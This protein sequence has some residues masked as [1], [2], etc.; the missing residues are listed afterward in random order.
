M[1]A[2]LFILLGT[3]FFLFF[4]TPSDIYAQLMINE[5][6]PN[7]SGSPSEP[8][9][10]IELYNSGNETVDIS[11][12]TISDTSGSTKSYT[13]PGMTLAEGEYVSYRRDTTSIALN[14]DGDGVEIKDASNILK[15]SMTFSTTIED[16]SWSRI[17]DGS[18]SFVNNSEPTEG[19]PNSAPPT[20]TPTPTPT[21]APTSTPTP[22]PSPTPTPKPTSTPTPTPKPTPTPTKTPTVTPEILGAAEQDEAT[23]S[24]AAGESEPDLEPADQHSSDETAQDVEA[25]EDGESAKDTSAYATPILIASSGLVLLVASS[26]PLLKKRV[27]DMRGKKRKQNGNPQSDSEEL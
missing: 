12:W 13:I 21:P 16:R 17:P 15:D 14:N 27:L 3:S 11:G 6:S 19:G 8:N 5:V 22:T 24:D 2:S 18:G 20:P 23:P 10:F 7:P 9:E 26:F 4:L 1:V 25:D